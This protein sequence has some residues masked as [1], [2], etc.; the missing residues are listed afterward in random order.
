MKLKICH[1]YPDVLNLYGDRGNILC[2]RKR[3][4]WRGIDCIIDEKNIGDPVDF[5]A[6]DFFF[7]GGGQDFEQALL[8][9]DC[10]KK[11]EDWKAA[12]EDGIPFLCVCGGYQLLGHSYETADGR[13]CEYLGA[14]DFYTVGSHDR[15]I[16]NLAFRLLPASGGSVVIGFENHGGRTFL[17]PG[18]EP[19]GIVLA[20]HGNGDRT[21]D[22]NGRKHGRR[23]FAEAARRSA[24]KSSLASRHGNTGKASAAA[25]TEGMRYK[26]V[27]GTYCHGPV[28]PKNPAFCD[29][30]LETALTRKYGSA[31]LEP[32][33][34]TLEQK[35]RQVMLHRLRLDRY[36]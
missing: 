30:L 32:L 28:L 13:H 27:F 2:L 36:C 6:Y 34:D 16:G 20:G 14:V 15:M 33:P 4:E 12:I 11:K 3:L 25:G 18:V 24:G 9:E 26:N 31:V 8:L 23:T 19:L 29:F 17:G 22:S 5:S 1:L 10:R 21:S 7:V 35:A